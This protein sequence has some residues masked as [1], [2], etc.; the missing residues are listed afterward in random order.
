MVMPL[1]VTGTST[2]LVGVPPS[3]DMINLYPY[4]QP[5]AEKLMDA[6][7]TKR[8]ALDNSDM[9]VGKTPVA[10][11]LADN[12]AFDAVLVICPKICITPWTEWLNETTRYSGG[13]FDVVTWGK[14]ARGTTEYV[15]RRPG[16][17]MEW[18]VPQDTLIIFD[19]CHNANGKKTWNSKLV[20]Y[21]AD[22]QLPM[23]FLS[24]TPFKTPMDF[25]AVGQALGVH[26]G[27]SSF[28]TWCRKNKVRR[29]AFGM[30]YRGGDEGL[31]K[32]RDELKD[33][34][35]NSRLRK[36]DPDVRA[37]FADN[38]ITAE[39]YNLRKD[40]KIDEL[41]EEI[42]ALEDLEVTEQEDKEK[43]LERLEA[44]NQYNDPDV[45]AQKLAALEQSTKLIK[46]LRIRQ[47]IELFKVP[48]FLELMKESYDNGDYPIAFVNHRATLEELILAL[49]K[50]NIP[51]CFLHGGMKQMDRDIHVNEFQTA[52]HPTA[53]VSTISAGG[54]GTNLHDTTGVA[55]RAVYIS[56]AYNAL[57]IQQVFGRAH[58]AGGLSLVRQQLVFVADT[59][60]EKV[61]HIVRRK[62]RNIA[63]LNDDD[64]SLMAI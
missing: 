48:L 20:K 12:I 40:F 9:G 18:K 55:P 10:A 60:E 24:A 36:T 57:H 49:E 41:Y 64:L 51:T 2:W 38:S 45:Y 30:E 43:Y 22:A 61:C 13:A 32:I 17:R 37:F 46:A 15:K 25:E 63:I 8:V 6:L 34:G 19:E 26:D 53:F 42:A 3:L 1:V 31:Q 16:K 21:A 23:L 29:G 54:T 39:A 35:V 33:L 58:R 11:W 28:W 27:G 4:Q 50:E 59:I 44:L 62:L 52:P 14:A 5:H 47:Q 7:L 56:P